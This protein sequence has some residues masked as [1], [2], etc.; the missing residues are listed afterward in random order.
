MGKTCL[1]LC[2]T[3]PSCFSELS[4]E[5]FF[6]EILKGL[7]LVKALLS[8]SLTASICNQAWHASDGEGLSLPLSSPL[9]ALRLP[10]C[11]GA[12]GARKCVLGARADAVR[13]ALRMGWCWVSSGVASAPSMEAVLVVPWEAGHTV[14]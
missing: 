4:N 14:G 3:P 1:A 10:L 9:P 13:S 8:A 2:A 7:D 5:L 11:P 12:A 6:H